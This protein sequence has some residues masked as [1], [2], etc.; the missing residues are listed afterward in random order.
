MH[1]LDYLKNLTILYAEDDEY[2]QQAL[3]MVLEDYIGNII[4]AKNG[5]EALK[6]FSSNKIDL[7]IADILMP[8]ING[9][10]LARIIKEKQTNIDSVPI[11]FATAFT[12]TE[13][14]LDSIKLRCDG[15]VLKPINID[16]LLEVIHSAMLPRIQLKEILSKN[17][18]LEFLDVFIGGKKIEVIKYILEHCNSQSIFYGSHDEI[19]DSC[20]TT[21]TTVA[22]TI[23][24]LIDL[25]LLVKVRNKTYHINTN[26]IKANAESKQLK[27]NA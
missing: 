3:S 11:I 24:Q 15:Y 13:Y 8:K 2:A 7:L 17:I 26:L 21:R 12:D 14:L 5:K 9:I 25:K 4:T 10:E 27:N 18:L 23:Q 19:A 16:N 22:K 1:K 6:L 20:G